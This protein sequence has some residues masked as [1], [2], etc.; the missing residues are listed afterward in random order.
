MYRLI[1]PLLAFVFGA[2][3]ALAQTT[4]FTY[5]GRLTDGGTPANGVY[6]LQFGLW[7][8]QT[9]AIRSAVRKASIAF[10]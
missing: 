3:T 1:A 6:D 4:G 2:S 7:D 5:Q 10:R 8:S 9:A